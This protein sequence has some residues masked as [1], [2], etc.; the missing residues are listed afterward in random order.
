MQERYF[1]QYTLAHHKTLM[2]NA[3]YAGMTP[4]ERAAVLAY[5]HSQGAGGANRWLNTGQVGSDAFGTAGTAYSRAVTTALQGTAQLAQRAN[6]QAGV[7]SAMNSQQ[8][9]QT[10]NRQMAS[11]DNAGR[12]QNI[13]INGPIIIHTQATD[14]PGVARALRGELA[15][16]RRMAAQAN[17]GLA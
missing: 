17:T 9:A 14:A 11:N 7:A 1:A 16:Q 10:A 6:R 2:R 5:A 3:R 4:E 13:D 8:Q 12:Q 15:G